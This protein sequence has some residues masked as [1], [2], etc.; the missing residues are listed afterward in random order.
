MCLSKHG[1]VLSDT[2]FLSTELTGLLE[3]QTISLNAQFLPSLSLPF[4][5]HL[6]HT[7]WFYSVYLIVGL[8]FIGTL[9]FI[10]TKKLSIQF[11]LQD[12]FFSTQ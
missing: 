10:L 2:K 12:D 5:R 1:E 7:S 11:A 8:R 9:S 6:F 4:L 3:K